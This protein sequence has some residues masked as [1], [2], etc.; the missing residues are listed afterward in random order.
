MQ[1]Q[2]LKLPALL[3]PADSIMGVFKWLH[4]HALV[5]LRMTLIADN[6]F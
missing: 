5:R 3:L 1:P 4:V 2:L 6:K